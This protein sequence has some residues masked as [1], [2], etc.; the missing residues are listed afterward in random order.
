MFFAQLYFEDREK[1]N[2][3][4][5]KLEDFGVASGLFAEIDVKQLSGK[6]SGP[7][8]IQLRRIGNSQAKGP[9][10]N[11]ID[12]GYGVSQVL[13]VI[14]ELRRRDA[15]PMMLL[16]QPEVHLHPRAQAA[17]G[18]LLCEVAASRRQ[19]VVETHGDYLIDRVRMA[20]RDGDTALKPDDVSILYFE[21]RNLDVQIHSI[22][23]DSEG[24]ISGAPDTYRQ[25][26]MEETSRS[27]W[28]PD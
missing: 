22:T 21:R 28:K 10:R 23:V 2:A 3:L 13:P 15:C 7:F 9:P 18:T 26:F 17:L 25:F 16:Q 8:Q 4:K 20:V 12:V 5:A 14:T 19:L 24:N 11:L 27:L 1:W 6:A